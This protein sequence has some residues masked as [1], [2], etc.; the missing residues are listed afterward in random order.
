MF[1]AS[2]PTREWMRRGPVPHGGS[3]NL[4][5]AI[6]VLILVQGVTGCNSPSSPVVSLPP[7]PNGP[8]PSVSAISPNIGS[9]D[10]DTPVTITGTF[11][12]PVS[13]SFAG[14]NVTGRFDGRD[15]QFRTLLLQTPPHVAGAVDVTVTNFNGV[16]QTLSGAFTYTSP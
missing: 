1:D 2:Y 15:T 9:I 4:R 3:M 14:I 16:S 7:A 11:Q 5:N 10:G 6:V 8:P 13:V 12:P